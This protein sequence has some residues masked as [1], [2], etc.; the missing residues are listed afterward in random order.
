MHVYVLSRIYIVLPFRKHSTENPCN[1]FRT[2]VSLTCVCI[3]QTVAIS[4]MGLNYFRTA[5]SLTCVYIFQ[6]VAISKMGLNYFRTAVSLTCVYIFQTVAISKMGLNKQFIDYIILIMK[7][8]TFF[9]YIKAKAQP[10]SAVTTF[11]SV[12]ARIYVPVNYSS[13]ISERLPGLNQ[14]STMKMKCLA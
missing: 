7:K 6:T 10:I 4:K 2:A 11:C 5:V 8:E 13:I 9:A 3:F 12:L 1:Y 14:C